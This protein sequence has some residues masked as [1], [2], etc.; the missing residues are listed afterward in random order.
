MPESD[1]KI[2]ILRLQVAERAF[3]QCLSLPVAAHAKVEDGKLTLLGLYYG[4]A[5]DAFL[6]GRVTGSSKEAKELVYSLPKP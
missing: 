2:R 5:E 4:E 3:V 1:L 6:R